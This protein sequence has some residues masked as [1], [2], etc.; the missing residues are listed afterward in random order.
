M[1]VLRLFVLLVIQV[2]SGSVFAQQLPAWQDPSVVQ[3]NREL[4]RAS[5]FSFE[6]TDMA[7]TGRMEKS[8][9][10]LSL[11]GIWKFRY[12]ENPAGRPVDFYKNS[13]RTRR[14]DDIRVPGNWEFQGFGVP[15]YVNVPYEWTDDPKPP[16]V[17]TDHNPVGSYKRDFE[18]PES[19]ME[20]QVYI[21]LGAVKSAFY[22][23]INGKQVGYSQ[24]SKTPAEFNIT[25]YI[26]PGKNTIAIEVYR[27]SDGSWL[28]CQDFW[29]VSGIERDVYL[30]ARPPLH[31]AD[32]F[33]KTGLVFNY[34]DGLLDLDIKLVNDLEQEQSP[35]VR[36]KLF[37]GENALSIWED[38]LVTMLAPGSS[39]SLNTSSA[40]GDIRPWS[41]ET[42]NLYRL[43]LELYSDEGVFLEAVTNRIGFRTSE[44]RNGQL[45]VNGRPVLLKGVN[46]HEHDPHTGHYVSRESMLKD[47]ALMKQYNINAVRTSHYPNDPYWYE[48]CDEYGLYVID[49]ANIESHGV[50]YDP[51]QTLGN[52]SIFLK[53]HL[54]RTIRMV[55]RDKNHPSVIIWSLGNEAGDGVCFDATYDWIRSKDSSRPIHY[56]RAIGGRNTDIFC[57]MY[58]KIEEMLGYVMKIRDK[59]LIQ[60][61]YAHSMGNS[62]GN[63]QDYWDL[64]EAHDQLQGGFIWDWVDQGMAAETEDGRFYWAFGGDYG[65]ADVPS[66]SNFC[67]N[68]LVFPDRTVQPALEEVKKV[69]QYIAFEPVP[70]RSNRIRIKNKY[71][72]KILDD[73]DIHW[74][75]MEEGKL[76]S[77]G[78]IAVSGLLPGEAGDY[79]LNLARDIVKRDTE[80]FLNFRAV[81]NRASGLIPEGHVVAYEQFQL[82]HGKRVNETVMDFLS[83]SNAVP[84]FRETETVLYITAGQVTYTVDKLSG[85]LVSMEL[86]GKKMMVDGPKPNFWRAEVDND[87]GNRMDERL[88]VWKELPEKLERVEMS[89]SPD[90]LTFFVQ[91]RFLAPD[92]S[93]G[94][95]VTYIFSG[96]G[97]VAVKQDIFLH[98]SNS[99]Y[100]ELPAFGVKMVLSEALSGLEYFGRGPHENYIDRNNSALVGRYTSTV[101]EQYV[102][103]PAPQEN[104][105]KTDV[106]WLVLFDNEGEGMM[107]RGLPLFEFSALRYSQEQLSRTTPGISH[108]S[109]LKP[110]ESVFL[111]VNQ[112][113]MGVGGDDSW[114]AQTHGMYCIPPRTMQ[115]IYFI[116]PVMRGDDGKWLMHQGSR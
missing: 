4:P 56:E 62:T 71:D 103:Y 77:E 109:D 46:R 27:W 21:H 3:I 49:E 61:E 54:D 95:L 114:G 85:Y 38:E 28:E 83:E 73:I 35:M 1:K 59:P 20:K 33:C 22:L 78:K 88:A 74:E 6:S 113:Q 115:F 93:S 24:G 19:W 106:R 102:A 45:L 12:S 67:M 8:R 43:V 39:V 96:T 52:N 104:G 5:L 90:S 99:G 34:R 94:L 110:Q 30:E 60:C 82:D 48:L 64:I 13:Y 101:D 44:I 72:F 55:E 100:P 40:I 87:F 50:G 17:P 14:W 63:L 31:I 111:T 41:A 37:D 11:N 9:N 32:I 23:W 76:I 79:D 66:D 116:K 89:W 108:M 7:M 51:E 16:E 53:S 10:Y 25:P 81:T 65:P 18:I 47:I 80:Y 26:V 58:M 68:G 69:Y 70:F 2:F 91:S 42:P 98:P 105:N 97:E 84:E 86:N 29:R 36:I 92:A 15:I 107:I 112:R 57:P 75:L